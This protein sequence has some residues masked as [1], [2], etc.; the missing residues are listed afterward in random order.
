[1]SD[2][3][4]RPSQRTLVIIPTYN[5]R[6]NLPL[7]V[8]RVHAARPDVARARSSTTE[9]PTAP[10]SSPTSWRWPIPTAST[11]CIA[12]ARPGSARPIWP[13]SPG[14]WAAGTRCWSRWMPTAPRSRGAVPAARRGRRGRR[15]VDRVALRR[16]RNGAQLAEA[17]NA[18]VEDGQR[19][20]ADLAGCRHRRHHRR[21]PRLPARG[22]RE[23]RAGHGRLE[24]LLLPDR[25]DLA[26]RSPTG[27]PSSRCPSRSPNANWA[28]RR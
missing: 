20:L 2:G 8:G 6:D 11:S 21:L 1:M 5:E 17:P 9:A 22:A 26:H 13:V 25:D 3:G 10:V 19:L 16:R 28:C 18:V 24:G 4:D 12:P 7:I 14:A 23:D 15:P 27:S